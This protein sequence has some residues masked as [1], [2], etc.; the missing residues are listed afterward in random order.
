MNLGAELCLGAGQGCVGGTWLLPLTSA[1]VC[2]GNS[3]DLSSCE[4]CGR[5]LSP[6]TWTPTDFLASASFSL[7]WGFYSQE[8][9]LYETET[10]IHWGRNHTPEQP[11]LAML[12][13]TCTFVLRMQH[14]RRC[15]WRRQGIWLLIYQPLGLPCCPGGAS[16]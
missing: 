4:G 2:L 14:Q 12:S 10:A 13:L 8:R 11:H 9:E 15:R 5:I 16:L 6:Q 7:K 3:L 1:R